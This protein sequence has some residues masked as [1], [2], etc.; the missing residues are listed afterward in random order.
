M[1][2]KSIHAQTASAIR[3][4]LRAKFPGIKFVVRSSTFSMGNAVDIEWVDGVH[5][6]EVDKI[7]NKYQYGNFNGM[8]DLYE[9]SNKRNDIPQVKYVMTQRT[10]SFELAKKTLEKIKDRFDLQIKI[11]DNGISEYPYKHNSYRYEDDTFNEKFNCY[12][13]NMIYRAERGTL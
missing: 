2:Q 5:T 12:E 8:I 7:V 3:K 9:Y 1:R 4:E 13:S 6:S 10:I 11:V